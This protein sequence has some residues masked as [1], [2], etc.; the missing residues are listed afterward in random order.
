MTRS[1]FLLVDQNSRH[2]ERSEDTPEFISGAI[3]VQMWQVR[4]GRVCAWK[5]NITPSLCFLFCVCV[6]LCSN[7]T[8]VPLL[9]HVCVRDVVFQPLCVFVSKCLPAFVSVSLCVYWVN[10][11]VNIRLTGEHS[12]GAL[13]P[14]LPKLHFVKG[15][16]D[17]NASSARAGASHAALYNLFSGCKNSH[18]LQA[19][20][21]PAMWSCNFQEHEWRLHFSFQACFHSIKSL[22]KGKTLKRD[23]ALPSYRGPAGDQRGRRLAAGCVHT[24]DRS[25]T[26]PQCRWALSSCPIYHPPRHKHNS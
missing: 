12:L 10:P 6:C 26:T 13:E 1:R 19:S 17:L 5:D 3:D 22:N 9:P 16:E 2:T 7:K 18:C 8:I 15:T 14:K 20:L 4:G 24:A 25:M 21:S 23:T 11:G